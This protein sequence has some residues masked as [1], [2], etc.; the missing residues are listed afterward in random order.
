MTMGKE[1]M[2]RTREAAAY[3]GVCFRTMQTYIAEGIIP[4]V[5][6][7]GR[8]LFRKSDLDAF[9]GNASRR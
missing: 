8:W 4:C 3:I 2:L 7:A 5:K 9:L 1:V 6:P